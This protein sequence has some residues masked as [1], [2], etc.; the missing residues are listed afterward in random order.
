MRPWSGAGGACT[1]FLNLVRLSLTRSPERRAPSAAARPRSSVISG[2]VVRDDLAVLRHGVVT[3]S[4]ALARA[5]PVRRT[6]KRP[7]TLLLTRRQSLPANHHLTS[8]SK[9]LTREG[10]RGDPGIAVAT[11]PSDSEL[12]HHGLTNAVGGCC[13]RLPAAAA[14]VGWS[15]RQAQQRASVELEREEGR[16]RR[17][18][19]NHDEPQTPVPASSP[20][21]DNQHMA[22]SQQHGYDFPSKKLQFTGRGEHYQSN[23]P[24][25]SVRPPH[26]GG[27]PLM[28]VE[29]LLKDT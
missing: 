22:V 11:G 14:G 6:T 3:Q 25:M 24:N 23:L 29:E 13:R 4:S 9:R 2:G 20:T 16:V 27:A 21:A 18:M 12:H 10:P 19:Q 8:T 7:A 5:A 1:W 15:A 26:R 28:F 17:T